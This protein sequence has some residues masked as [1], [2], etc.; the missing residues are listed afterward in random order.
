MNRLTQISFTA[1]PATLLAGTLLMRLPDADYVGGPWWAAARAVL[2]AGFLM[3]GVMITALRGMGGPVTGGWRAAVDT[4][5]GLALLST[6]A[7]VVGLAVDLYNR[8]ESQRV[9]AWEPLVYGAAFAALVA[10]ASVLAALRRVTLV[11]AV[12]TATGVAVLI[13]GLLQ[14][15]L[16]PVGMALIWLGTLLLSRGPAEPAGQMGYRL[17]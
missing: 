5:T 14:P 7:N 4:A 9:M 3:F 15:A 8:F 2:L 11:S 10:L 12:V 13:G 16:T 17:P 1:A 6:A